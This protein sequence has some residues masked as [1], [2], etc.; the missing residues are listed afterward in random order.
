[1]TEHRAI[2]RLVLAMTSLTLFAGAGAQAETPTRPDPLKAAQEAQQRARVQA[3]QLQDSDQ[4][5]VTTRSVFEATPYQQPPMV[6]RSTAER[7]GQRQ[8]AADLVPANRPADRV[9]VRIETRVQ[10]RIANRLDR[11]NALQPILS[12]FATAADQARV[13]AARRR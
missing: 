5:A 13:A 3:Q 11:Y 12:P 9:D 1:V 2:R 7:V 4:S 10:S 6:P 8:T